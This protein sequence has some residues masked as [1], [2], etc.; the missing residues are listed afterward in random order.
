MQQLP[1]VLDI[2]VRRLFFDVDK[3]KGVLFATDWS[4]LC[5]EELESCRSKPAVGVYPGP[6]DLCINDL[7]DGTGRPV[8]VSTGLL[9][10]CGFAP[11][12]DFQFLSS[13]QGTTW[14]VVPAG[15]VRR[16]GRVAI[17]CRTTRF[18]SVI[19]D[20]VVSMIFA[21]SGNSVFHWENHVF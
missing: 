5:Y 2:F 15:R 18:Q 20:I 14:P 7:V 10:L 4:S 8:Q 16:P 3:K 13:L 12:E 6:A 9:G 19:S 21:G 17:C 11:R 1:Q